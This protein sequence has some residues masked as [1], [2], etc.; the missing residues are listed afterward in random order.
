VS[1]ARTVETQVPG[2][3]DRLPW[4]RWHTLVIFALGVTWVLDGIE[5]SIAGN[6]ADALTNPE[7]GL[8]FSPGQIGTATGI[9]I[10]GA[11]TGALFFSYLT[12]RYG[13]KKLFLITLAVYLI[14]SVLTA[15]SWNFASFVVFRFLA[16]MGIGGEYSAIY[17]A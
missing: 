14:F 1:E 6:I 17:S 11:C 16:G 7:T 13:R 5:V 9:Y 12:D 3:I 2:R 8:G 4:S 15:F 10:A